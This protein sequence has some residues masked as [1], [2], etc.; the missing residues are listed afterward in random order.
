MRTSFIA[1]FALASLPASAQ[2]VVETATFND[3][4]FI[5]TGNSYFLD[6]GLDSPTE[7]S[8]GT[9]VRVQAGLQILVDYELRIRNQGSVATTFSYMP[10]TAVTPLFG[11]CM[12]YRYINS[13]GTSEG[14]IPP[15]AVGVLSDVR[16]VSGSFSA[17]MYDGFCG[18]PW[19][20]T[21]LRIWD[22]VVGSPPDLTYGSGGS[23][24]PWVESATIDFQVNGTL[25]V[26]WTPTPVPVQSI[27]PGSYP[28][29]VALL[30]G[31]PR[32]NF[33]L[34]Q[35]G[36]PDAYNLLVVSREA[37]STVPASGLCVGGNGA[38]VLRLPG[39]L[40]QGGD[41]YRWSYPAVY[42]GQTLFVQ[43]YFRTPGGGAATGECVAVT[44]P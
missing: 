21:E 15:G 14:P 43:S 34:M 30:A 3:E 27:C 4:H 38:P 22:G 20:W 6:L 12:P 24:W 1:L 16:Q 25:R 33:W 28:T 13:F 40:S 31:G 44:M 17:T 41:P 11:D 8:H 10:E 26:E 7:A 2:T 18:A 36:A 5:A 29:P 23:A 42:A 35:D 19:P 32:E 37:T 9:V 39:S